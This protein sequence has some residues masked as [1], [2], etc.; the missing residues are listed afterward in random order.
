VQHHICKLS[1]KSEKLNAIYRALNGALQM[2]RMADRSLLIAACHHIIAV[3]QM[4]SS[5]TLQ[6]KPLVIHMP[7][8]QSRKNKLCIIATAHYWL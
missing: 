6:T 2:K 3:N 7:D 8:E 1:T 5:Y 4:L